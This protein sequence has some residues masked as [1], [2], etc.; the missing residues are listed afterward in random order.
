MNDSPLRTYLAGKI[1]KTGDWRSH[2]LG[3]DNPAHI[4]R[5]ADGPFP[6]RVGSRVYTYPG[7]FFAS[8]DHGCGHGPG[9]HGVDAGDSAPYC[10]GS[11]SS[12][13]DAAYAA[14]GIKP[15]DLDS[16]GS[17]RRPAVARLCLD[18]L[19]RADA[20]YLFIDDSTCH[21]SLVE[22]G[23][24]LAKCIPSRVCFKSESLA[25]EVWFAAAALAVAPELHSYAVASDPYAD[26]VAWQEE[27]PVSLSAA[28]GVS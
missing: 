22:L 28:G 24:A 1:R 4:L 17:Q 16:G 15:E 3:V 6:F 12:G 25:D 10:A 11:L 27:S 19:C 18:A 8:C 5:D 2:F 21:G 20:L 9:S 13:L 14:A 7:P 23:F 26:F